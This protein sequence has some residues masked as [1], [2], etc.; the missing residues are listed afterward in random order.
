MATTSNRVGNGSALEPRGHVSLVDARFDVNDKFIPAHDEFFFDGYHEGEEQ[1]DELDFF[2]IAG[3]TAAEA[4]I[5]EYREDYNFAIAVGSP[6]AVLGAL[7]FAAA[8]GVYA[9]ST[10][11]P[12]PPDTVGLSEEYSAPVLFLS[13]VGA[14][15]MAGGSGL[16]YLL[17]PAHPNR[18]INS[19]AIISYRRALDAAANYNAR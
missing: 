4:D 13:V 8:A 2:H 9:Y 14:A 6:V 18:D 11:Q 16:F 12:A 17:A 5:V 15:L 1:I 19:S 10:T 7:S 3:D